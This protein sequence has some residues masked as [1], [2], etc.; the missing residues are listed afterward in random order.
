M[1]FV[2]VAAREASALPAALPS[3]SLYT[4]A[5]DREWARLDAQAGEVLRLDALLRARD[6]SLVQ[7]HERVRQFEEQ[8]AH[9]ERLIAE[10]DARLVLL[11]GGGEA[12]QRELDAARAEIA[13][14]EQ[15]CTALEAERQR[16]EGAVKAQE[17]IIAYRQSIRWWMLLPWVRARRLWQ[18]LT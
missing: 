11:Q 10:R 14:L 17:R 18:R 2:V 6:A 12:S 9:R 5:D 16:L 7:Q 8:M 15:R 3:F 13:S 4:D 1:Y